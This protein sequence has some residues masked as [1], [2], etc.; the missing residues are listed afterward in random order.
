MT[1]TAQWD[2]LHEHYEKQDWINKPNIFAT[3]VIQYFPK[4]GKTL[5]LGDGQGQ[6]SRY[7]SSLGYKVVATDIS[8]KALESNKLAVKA[9]L[10]KPFPFRD[11]E[12]DVVYAHLSLHYFSTE[13]TEQIFKEIKRV[14]KIEGILAVFVNSVNDPEFN[15]GKRL[16]QEFFEIDG[17]PKRFFSI[18]SM[19]YFARDFTP[20]LLDDHGKT[21]KDEAKGVHNLV[22]FVGINKPR[23]PRGFAC[24]FVAAI[25]ERTIDGD[26]QKEILIQD[27]YRP[28]QKYHGAI[29]IPAGVLDHDFE[30]IFDA[31]KR[32]VKEETGLTVKN[33]EQLS[34][35]KIYSPEDDGAYS[36]R[37]F[38]C[39]QQLKGGLPW[40]GFVFK[41]EVEGG[42]PKLQ[43]SET[44]NIRWITKK[45]LG[46]LFI[47]SPEKFFTLHLGALEMYLQED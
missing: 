3:E 36:F 10:T 46:K 19:D 8:E 23:K 15:T 40:V 21:Y 30:N 28:G 39:S 26:G 7:F 47:D 32:E 1:D 9:D 33:I 17:T 38:V 41:C 2:K 22:R 4:K 43:E 6:D 24:P 44:R 11:E 14:L 31:L 20:I 25:I 16:E 35:T 5:C 29:E 42:E 18:F 13:V 34:K 27:R 45:E 12:F 37:P